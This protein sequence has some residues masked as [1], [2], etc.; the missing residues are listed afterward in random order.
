MFA[1]NLKNC[2]LIILTLKISSLESRPAPF[3]VRVIND[4]TSGLGQLAN[5]LFSGEP[6]LMP[7]AGQM[8]PMGPMVPSYSPQQ[9]AQISPQNTSQ[10]LN[11]NPSN[12]PQLAMLDNPQNSRSGVIGAA[13]GITN[14]IQEAL[15]GLTN[16]ADTLVRGL[17][18]TRGNPGQAA[19]AWV[20]QLLRATIL[21][22]ALNSFSLFSISFAYRQAQYN[23]LTNAQRNN[24]QNN[25]NTPGNNPSGQG[26]AV[27]TPPSDEWASLHKMCGIK[28]EIHSK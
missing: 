22:L 15:T 23:A 25:A 19:L 1:F 28:D 3:L 10:P 21:V 5:G 12:F 18:G 27:P 26:T 14:V 6:V 8:G 11:F 9:L 4:I 24:S 7:M 17:W 13:Q 2:L 16:T 20:K